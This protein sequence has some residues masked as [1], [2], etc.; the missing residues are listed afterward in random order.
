MNNSMLSLRPLFILAVLAS[1]SLFPAHA[2]PTGLPD[3]AMAWVGD[4]KQLPDFPKPNPEKAFADLKALQPDGSAYRTPKED[5]AGA[6]RLISE[7][8]EWRAWVDRRKASV[9]A[10]MARHHDRVEWQ[11]GWWHDFVSPD[12]AAFLVW[13]EDIPGEQTD[14]FT[15]KRGDRVEIT[16]KL[17]G[18][19]VYGFR[20]RHIGNLVTAARLYRLTGDPSY[21]EWAGGQLDFYANNLE[22]WPVTNAKKNDARLGCQSLDDA[23]LLARL[24]ETARLL[25][26]WATPEHRKVW[27]DQLLKPEAELLDRSF[28]V[29]HNIAVWHRAAQAQVAL[30]GGDEAMW[31]RVVDGEF[32]LRA[33]FS[34][35]VTSDYLWYEQSMGYNDYIVDATSQLFVFAGLLGHADRLR[36]EA[37]IAQNLLLAPLAIRFPDGRLPNP[38]DINKT[39][40]VPSAWIQRTYRTLPTTIGLTAAASVRDWDTLVDPPAPS[41]RPP[42]PPAVVSV[43]LASSRFALLKQGPWQVFL[44]YGQVNRSHSQAEALNWSA[45]FDG[46]DVSHDPGTVGYGSPLTNGYYRRGLCHNLPLIDGEGQLPWQPG[47]LPLFDAARAIMTGV[48]PNYRPEASARRTLRIDGDRLIDEATITCT[49]PDRTNSRLGLSLNLQGTPLPSAAFAPDAD[50]AQGRPEPFRYWKDVRSATFTD[51]ATIDLRLTNGRILR[52]HFTVPGRFVTYQGSSPDLP[53]ARRAGFYLESLDEHHEATF[54]TELSPV[55]SKP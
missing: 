2:A 47:A 35:G 51:E 31:S 36:D 37:A 19:W 27:F 53:P 23:N 4:S 5:W 34:R 28:Q 13:T 6:R 40:T 26:D 45:T 25:N 38:A 21:A 44:H 43:Q 49:Q 18:A 24:V 7:D 52:V 42:E 16:P 54:T 39:I 12:D 22:R 9:D 30:L 14:H 55:E 32:G 1:T 33:Q 41:P 10:W 15:S 11:A 8:P 3:Q 17:F 29:I 48:Q 50:F 20:Q 46:I